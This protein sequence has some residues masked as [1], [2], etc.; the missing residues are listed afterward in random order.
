MLNLF[1]RKIHIIIPAGGNGSRF[2]NSKFKELKPFIKI[3]G[4]TI[5]E[6]I[7]LNVVSIYIQILN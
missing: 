2:K 3:N 5:F 1:K 6:H 7:I 4:K